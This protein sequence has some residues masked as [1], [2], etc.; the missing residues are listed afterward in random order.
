MDKLNF[1]SSIKDLFPYGL[2]LMPQTYDIFELELALKEFHSLNCEDDFVKRSAYFEEINGDKTNHYNLCLNKNK[3]IYEK[4]SVSTRSFLQ[5]NMFSSN[6]ATHGFFPYRGKFHP[7]MIK[8]IMNII[9]LKPGD[10]ILDPMCGSGTTC[11]EAN[12]I[13]I[14]SIGVDISPFCT[15]MTYVKCEYIKIHFP[16]LNNLLSYEPD[17]IEFYSEKNN[18][19][20]D[21]SVFKEQEFVKACSFNEEKEVYLLKDLLLLV[22]LDAMGYAR[23]RVNKTITDV[24]SDVLNKYLITITDFCSFRSSLNLNIGNIQSINSC[25]INLPID[26]NSIDAIITSPR[27]LLQSIT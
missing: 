16:H 15:L 19:L 14:N 5:A 18:Y 27:I 13:G 26:D 25:C 24:F 20:S 2:K 17:I 6:Y 9:G 23:R 1:P 7:Q 3:K 8:S 10:T 21:I 11:V 4:K 22:Y 12:L